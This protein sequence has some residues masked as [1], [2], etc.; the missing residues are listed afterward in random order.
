MKVNLVNKVRLPP[1]Q[2][3]FFLIK[4]TISARS[5]KEDHQDR[6]CHDLELC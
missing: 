3:G 5:F 1:S 6:S 2:Q 4:I